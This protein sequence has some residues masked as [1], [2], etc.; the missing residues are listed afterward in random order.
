MHLIDLP[1]GEKGRGCQDVHSNILGPRYLLLVH[2][3]FCNLKK[4]TVMGDDPRRFVFF[5]PKDRFHR[6][7]Q[8]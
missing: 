7:Y 2:H 6:I 3:V 5:S 8:A 4:L 1:L